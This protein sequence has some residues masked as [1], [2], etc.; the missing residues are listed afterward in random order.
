MAT[1]Y[2][3]AKRGFRLQPSSPFLELFCSL[4]L[5]NGDC[6]G[7]P[8]DTAEQVQPKLHYISLRAQLHRLHIQVKGECWIVGLHIVTKGAGDSTLVTGSTSSVYVL[9]HKGYSRKEKRNF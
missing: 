2:Y 5:V 7:F 8:L 3:M 9:V 4:A 1:G 6:P